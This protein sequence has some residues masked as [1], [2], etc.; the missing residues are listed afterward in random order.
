MPYIKKE[1]RERWQPV[2]AEFKRVIQDTSN[3]TPIGEINYLIT[4]LLLEYAKSETICYTTFNSI[5]GVLANIQQEFYR[6]A[7]VPYEE[8]KKTEHG[9]VF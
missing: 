6:R 2:I 9:D 8:T 3:S 5:I 1:N 7:V 4:Q